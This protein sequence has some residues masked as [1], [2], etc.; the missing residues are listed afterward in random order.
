[1]ADWHCL[2]SNPDSLNEYLQ[3][4]EFDTSKFVFHDLFSTEEWA[5][6]M[7]PKPTLA[8]LLVFPCNDKALEFKKQEKDEIKSKGQIVAPDLFFIQQFALNS[9]G[10]VAIYHVLLNLENEFQSLLSPN[11]MVNKFK[12]ENASKNI[13]QKSQAFAQSSDI[14]SS[15]SNVVESGTTSHLVENNNHFVAFINYSDH[16]YEMDGTKD[17]PIN[18]GPTNS[19]TFLE[20]ACREVKKFMNRDPENPNFSLLCLAKKD[21]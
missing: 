6:N 7:I 3:K 18:H 14:K 9:C 8:L 17:F 15:H 12:K 19:Q 20:D 10:T 2:E 11:S 16:I 21:E 1:M 13:E 4:L 5:R